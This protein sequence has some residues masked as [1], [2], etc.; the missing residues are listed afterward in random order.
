M[1]TI[2]FETSHA[3]SVNQKAVFVHE[4]HNNNAFGRNISQLQVCND[5]HIALW[6]ISKICLTPQIM[7]A[8]ASHP[9]TEI[10][11]IPRKEC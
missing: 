11:F 4:T 3:M 1:H 8:H 9:S 2:G 10:M 7:I 5:C 6:C